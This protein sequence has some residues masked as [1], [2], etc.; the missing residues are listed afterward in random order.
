[1]HVKVLKLRPTDMFCVALVI[2]NIVSPM[3]WK[4]SLLMY[5]FGSASLWAT[6]QFNEEVKSRTIMRLTDEHFEGCIQTALLIMQ[7]NSVK[8]LTN[9]WF[10]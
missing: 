8:Y 9:D 2:C 6:V 10:C 3:W 7:K 5:Q 1:M 4:H